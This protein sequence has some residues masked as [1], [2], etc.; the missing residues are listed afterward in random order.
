MW[1]RMHAHHLDTASLRSGHHAPPRIG[2][3]RTNP[4]PQALASHEA[5]C[6]D[7]RARLSSE[8]EASASRP[9]TDRGQRVPTD[10]ARCDLLGHA[11][12]RRNLL[13]LESLW[14]QLLRVASGGRPP[15]AATRI[16]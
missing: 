10:K 1:G 16:A 3:G 15:W 11:G 13:E 4:W 12:K 9:F 14:Q 2:A 5:V 6:T 8:A 7:D